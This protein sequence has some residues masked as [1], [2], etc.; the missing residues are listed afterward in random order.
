MRHHQRE[1]RY[2]NRNFMPATRRLQWDATEGK[3]RSY[4]TNGAEFNEPGVATSGARS[5]SISPIPSPFSDSPGSDFSSEGDAFWQT[6]E[7]S[8]T[9]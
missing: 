4:N 6:L 7:R 8:D 2:R 1:N 3:N 5:Q 9:L